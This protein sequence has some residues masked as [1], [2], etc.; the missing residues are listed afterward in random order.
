MSAPTGDDAPI[1]EDDAVERVEDLVEDDRALRSVMYTGGDTEYAHIYLAA[2]TGTYRGNEMLWLRY[3]WLSK[4]G[5]YES[6]MWGDN[7]ISMRMVGDMAGKL[8]KMMAVACGP[9]RAGQADADRGVEY[10][11]A[12]GGE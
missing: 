7:G 11:D 3:V 9:L 10:L 4:P 1:A 5:A 8:P 12:G 6:D 2:V